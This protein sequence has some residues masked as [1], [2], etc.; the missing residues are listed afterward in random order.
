MLGTVPG[1]WLNRLVAAR[2][3]LLLFGGLMGLVGICMLR[4]EQ[5]GRRAR[6]EPALPAV[7]PARDWIR[8][9][10]LGASVGVLT[11]FFG[12]G[13]GFMIMPALGLVGGLIAHHAVGTSLLVIAMTSGA[14]LVGHLWSG[15][16]DPAVI[17]VFVVGGAVGILSGTRLAGYLPERTLA[18]TFGWVVILLALSVIAQNLGVLTAGL[19]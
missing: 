8:F 3:I 15:T 17:G 10:G 2:V 5:G 9:S 13:G 11:G 6:P 7:F 1:V 19:R 14:G 12:I 18:K 16:V 4:R